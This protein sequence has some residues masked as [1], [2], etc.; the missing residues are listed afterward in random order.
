MIEVTTVTRIH[1]PIERCFDI[2]RDIDVHTRTVWKHT[3]ERA[4]AGVTSGM[5][6]PGDTVTFEAVHFGVR[7]TLTSRITAY[8]RPYLFVDQ[9]ER[10]RSRACVMSIISACAGTKRL[11]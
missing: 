11:V 5:I 9:M 8:D 4:I 6:G 7:Q 3:Q 1:A 2:A 10:G